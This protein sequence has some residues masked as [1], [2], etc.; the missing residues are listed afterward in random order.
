MKK[1]K[2]DNTNGRI[3]KKIEHSHSQSSAA[4]CYF[5]P[6]QCWSLFWQAPNSSW[7]EPEE[8]VWNPCSCN[9]AHVDACLSASQ[10]AAPVCTLWDRV[11]VFNKNLKG[12]QLRKIP[13]FL[14]HR[15]ISTA[16]FKHMLNIHL[17]TKKL[18]TQFFF[19]REAHATTIN[20]QFSSFWPRY[21][22]WYFTLCLYLQP[23]TK[24]FIIFNYLQ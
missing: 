20:F 2:K 9:P 1:K 10:L 13:R 19:E 3:I 24:A 4:D 17:K 6:V 11:W 16:Y 7:A 12:A 15:E 18:R 5:R 23:D 21:S 14:L 8:I 22:S